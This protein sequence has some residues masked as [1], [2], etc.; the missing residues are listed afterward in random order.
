[1]GYPA[2]TSSEFHVVYA[3]E[4]MYGPHKLGNHVLGITNYSSEGTSGI[5]LVHTPATIFGTLSQ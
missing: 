1:M 2:G 4:K 5:S 3:D